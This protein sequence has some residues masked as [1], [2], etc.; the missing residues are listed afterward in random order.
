MIVLNT[1]PTTSRGVFVDILT[2]SGVEVVSVPFIEVVPLFTPTNLELVNEIRQKSSPWV[3]CTSPHGVRFFSEALGSKTLGVSASGARFA[4]NGVV[5]GEKSALMWYECFGYTPAV[6]ANKPY[7]QGLA[8]AFCD[9]VRGGAPCTVWVVAPQN[10]RGE[11]EGLLGLAGHK[12][13]VVSIYHTNARVPTNSE[14][15]DILR[16]EEGHGV[17]SFFSPSAVQ[18]FFNFSRLSLPPVASSRRRAQ[19]EVP[20]RFATFGRTTAQAITDHGASVWLCG[21]A[22]DERAFAQMIVES[23]HD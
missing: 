21:D 22:R 1:R 3:V 6:V 11:V 17:V 23:I 18:S 15:A 9:A 5:Q 10:G 8:D 16:V 14:R 2:H 12:A 7:A 19:W 4:I 13:L 20:F